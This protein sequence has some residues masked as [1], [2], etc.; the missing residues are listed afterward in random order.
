METKETL[1][2]KVTVFSDYICPFCFIGKSRID[3]LQK[4]FDVEVE[5][6]NMEIH[7]ETPLNGIPISKIDSSFFTQ[8]WL[9]V[10][11]LAK[12][13]GIE[14][15]PPKV[16]SNSSLAMIAAEYARQKNL[17][18]TFHDAVFR[19][20]W[21]EGKNIGDL[22][23]L[24]EIAKIIGLDPKGLPAYIKEGTWKDTIKKQSRN[25]QDHQVSGV[26]TFIIG[27]ETVVGAQPYS[28][29]KETFSKTI[30]SSKQ[31]I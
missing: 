10:E 29:I 26:P 14:I 19:A 24:M 5:W 7:P 20:Y 31:T 1:K 17:F 8:L 4:E 21:Q 30:N 6:K 3:K 25:A 23:V 11:S 15:S 16:M 18:E 9:S 2:S 22:K 12:E 27:E 13:S 28:V